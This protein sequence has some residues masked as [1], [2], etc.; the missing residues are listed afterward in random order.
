MGVSAAG[1]GMTEKGERSVDERES[2][3]RI[4]GATVQRTSVCRW[5]K[6]TGALWVTACYWRVLVSRQEVCM[7]GSERSSRHWTPRRFRARPSRADRRFAAFV[8]RQP[9][10]VTRSERGRGTEIR[11]P[12]TAAELTVGNHRAPRSVEAVGNRP[13]CRFT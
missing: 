11:A 10:E 8:G 4:T 12:R 1:D 2:D 9:E 7:A 3:S 5:L 13:A 6:G